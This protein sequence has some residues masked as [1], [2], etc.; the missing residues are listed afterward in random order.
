MP[1]FSAGQLREIGLR[2]FKAAGVQPATAEKVVGSLVLSNLLGVDSHGLVRTRNYFDAVRSG[3]IVP[4]ARPCITHENSVAV[5]FDGC[6]AFG[7]VAAM[8]AVQLAIRKAREQSIGVT[9]FTNVYH[10]GRLGEWVSLIADEG[11]IGILLANGS[12]PGGL[13][14]PFGARQRVL[15]TNPMAF[16]IPAGSQPRLVADFSTSAVAE[17]KVRIAMRKEERVPP[18]CL[19]DRHGVATTEPADLYDGGAIRTFGDHK[20][21]A[22]SLLVEVVGGILSGAETPVF[23]G[24]KYM[25]NGVFLLAIDPT[26]FRPRDEYLAA[27]DYLFAAVK[28]ALPAYGMDG[29]LIPG[30]PEE[31]VR[32]IRSRNGIPVDDQTWAELVA[33]ASEFGLSLQADIAGRAIPLAAEAGSAD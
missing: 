17:G 18:G 13:V 27:V 6:K 33:V 3:A 7:Q 28:N 10:I 30:E 19:L 14:A 11:L 20:G 23:P 16:A 12:R 15:G 8:F 1:I 32:E 31:R 21:F 29:T 4:E 5:A 24:Y 9:S 25:H 26:F 2:I 22:L